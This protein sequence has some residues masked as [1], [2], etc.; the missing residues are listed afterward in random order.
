MQSH[1]KGVPIKI[2]PIS[3]DANISRSVNCWEIVLRTVSVM[4][5]CLHSCRF[6]LL[7]V[8][9]PVLGCFECYHWFLPCHKASEIAFENDMPAFSGIFLTCCEG[10][11]FMERVPPSSTLY[12]LHHRRGFSEVVKLTGTFFVL[13]NVSKC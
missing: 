10:F 2:V 12:I 11:F 5:K 3:S 1:F 7:L 4:Q 6:H 13:D 9:S 8:S